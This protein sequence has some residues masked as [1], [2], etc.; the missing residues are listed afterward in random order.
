L[1]TNPD[2]GEQLVDERYPRF[3]LFPGEHR[4]FALLGVYEQ[5]VFVDPGLKLVMMHMAVAKDAKDQPTPH[6]RGALWRGIVRHYG[7]W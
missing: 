4:R 2:A 5:A 7:P 6:Q 3:W 1:S